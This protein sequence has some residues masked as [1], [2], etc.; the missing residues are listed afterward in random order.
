M[1]IVEILST[2]LFK[3]VEIF[4]LLALA[5]GSDFIEIKNAAND[6]LKKFDID[7]ILKE[8]ETITKLF[9]IYLGDEPNVRFIFLFLF[10]DLS[11]ILVNILFNI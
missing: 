2:S 7:E 5:S 10:F 1:A 4:P 9:K 11:L 6:S 3:K 8:K